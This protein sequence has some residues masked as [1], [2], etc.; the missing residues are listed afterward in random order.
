MCPQRRLQRLHRY[1]L[2]LTRQA[3]GWCVIIADLK[4]RCILSRWF[5]PAN[6]RFVLG[7]IGESRHSYHYRALTKSAVMKL[8]LK[9]TGQQ[10]RRELRSAPKSVLSILRRT[11]GVHYNVTDIIDLLTLDGVCFSRGQLTSH[12]DDLVVQGKLA[13]ITAAPG[14]VFY[15]CNTSPHPHIFNPVTGQLSDLDAGQLLAKQALFIEWPSAA[16]QRR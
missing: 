1:R 15:D 3:G 10:I 9:A 8:M 11:R 16:T 4:H 14:C 6:S 5:E 2:R 12:L 7:L 13:K